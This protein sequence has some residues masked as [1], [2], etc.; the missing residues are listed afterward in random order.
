MEVYFTLFKH[1]PSLQV[2][3]IE[4]GNPVLFPADSGNTVS[5]AINGSQT[6]SS[7]PSKSL[8]VSSKQ[9]PGQVSLGNRAQAT[10]GDAERAS[11]GD[12]E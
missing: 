4:T 3:Q 1:W 7:S 10:S 9:P 11:P 6:G 8:E 5:V 12:S 2:T